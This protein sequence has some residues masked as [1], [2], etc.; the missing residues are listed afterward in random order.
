MGKMTF[1]EFRDLLNKHIEE[2][3]ENSEHLFTVD[4]DKDTM[5]ETYLNAFPKG[6]NPIYRKQTIHDCSCCRHFIKSFGNVVTVKN[7][8]VT[9]IWDFECNDNIY[10]LVRQAMCVLIHSK[11]IS[12]VYIS[13][14]KKIST[15]VNYEQAED[16]D[17]IYYNHF[18]VEVPHKFMAVNNLAKN[19]NLNNFRTG[20]E[21]LLRALNEISMDSV[22]T[23]LDLI[24]SNTLYK[25]PE[26]KKMVQEF[27]KL[28]VEFV[29]INSP[30]AQ[31]I[32]A[33]EMSTKLGNVVS[34]IRNHAIGT[35]LVDISNGVDIEEA[36]KKYET[37]TAP[38]N[39][40]RSKQ[41]FLC[42]S[43]EERGSL[44][45]SLFNCWCEDAPEVKIIKSERDD[46]G[47]IKH[48]YFKMGEEVY[49]FTS[50]EASE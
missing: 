42:D 31:D 30:S 19:E 24:D 45:E 50:E 2:M 38:S 37:I 35:L 4:V 47:N 40:K 25:G 17:V 29:T 5:W 46:E 28:K 22:D 1:V 12:N 41:E 21:V 3:F 15:K 13:T 23:V 39:Y 6:T 10:D 7:S 20:K 33:W 48:L 8:K 27:K 11:K 16:G 43:P 26:Y 9:S 49:E 32:F 14:E 36:V 44:I 34:R 18:Y